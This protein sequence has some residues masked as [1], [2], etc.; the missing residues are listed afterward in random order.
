MQF[1]RRLGH[2]CLDTIIKM[3]N[4]PGSGIRLTD[5]KRAKCLACA[6]GKQSKGAQPKK[7]TGANSP[8]DEIGG[9]I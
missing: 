2:L 9:V 3:A 6:Q 4:D 8:I 5:T 1:H 7:D